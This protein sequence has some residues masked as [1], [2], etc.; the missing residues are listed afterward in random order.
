ALVTGGCQVVGLL[1]LYLGVEQSGIAP[2]A[3]ESGLCLELRAAPEDGAAID[4]TAMEQAR[5][6]VAARVEMTG[7]VDPSIEMVGEDHLL[8]R[9]PG[10]ADG[11]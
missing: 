5:A 7:I 4:A 11:T 10:P 3:T 1:P 6:V 2:P 9:L 8:V